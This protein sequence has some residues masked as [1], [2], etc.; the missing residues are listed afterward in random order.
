VGKSGRIR[1]AA[2]VIV[3]V[4][5]VAGA[6]S[7]L[8]AMLTVEWIYPADGRA[9]AAAQATAPAPA[10]AAAAREVVAPP[11]PATPAPAKPVDPSSPQDEQI[12]LNLLRKASAGDVAAALK[13][14]DPA[15][16][17][18]ALRDQVGRLAATPLRAAGLPGAGRV[19]IWADYARESG[20]RARGAYDLTVAGGQ[21][22]QLKGPLAP[23]GGFKP[24]PFEVLDEDARKLDMAPYRGRGLLLVSPRLPEPGLAE[25]LQ[26]LSTTFAPQGV[27]VALLLDI[28][29]PDWAQAA[30]Q[31]GFDGPVWR[32]KAR[33]EDVPLVSRGQFLGAYGVLV[34]R[35]GYAVASLAALDPS[36]HGLPDRTVSDVAPVVL[37][38]YGLLP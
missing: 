38:A 31:G 26:Q 7:A 11:A 13:L 9:A 10:A 17:A 22:T 2:A 14:A 21:V 35:E 36:R 6:L 24:L 30:R 29:S 18:E 15:I 3:A 19:L 12:A 5:L 1:N 28:R 33:L 25:T 32:A 27:T 20:G 34:D 37:R 23:E 8:V 4:A 16:T